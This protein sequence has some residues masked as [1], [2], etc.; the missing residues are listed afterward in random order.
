MSESKDQNSDQNLL[1]I[2]QK[3]N[4][5][6][7]ELK[8]IKRSNQLQRLQYWKLA[9]SSF[10]MGFLGG[11][12]FMYFKD[13][14]SNIGYPFSQIIIGINF[15][16]RIRLSRSGKTLLL[17]AGLLIP[18]ISGFISVRILNTFFQPAVN[19]IPQ[20]RTFY[21]VYSKQGA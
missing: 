6:E 13:D 16:S 5:H 9:L 1:K 14:A 7:D 12:I 10:V 21:G 11:W 2:A 20:T 15:T 3:V 19:V 17:I 18:V 4:L 8:T